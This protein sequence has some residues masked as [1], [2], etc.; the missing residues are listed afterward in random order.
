M[1]N[2]KV[3]LFCLIFFT[4]NN[5]FAQKDY[6][7]S[8]HKDLDDNPSRLF[9]NDVH[10]KAGLSCKDCHGG[11]ASKEDM[12]A[13]MNKSTGFRGVPKGDRISE[14]CANC[15][16]NK[17][18]IMKFSSA[19]STNQLEELKSSAHG[20]LS[21]NGKDRILQCTNCH[22]AHGIKKKNDP[23]SSVYPVNI[24][25]TCTK[26]HNNADY[27]KNYNSALPVDQLSKYRTSVHGV[28]NQKGNSKTAECAS[29]HGS[30][31]I[32]SSKDV[33]S[34]VY[35][36]NIPGTCSKCH[37]D[38]EYMKQ[39][40]IPTNQFA[41]YRNSVHGKAV[42]EKQE[43]SAPVCN[44]CHGN[45][46]ATPPGI[47]SISNVCGNCHVL[48]SQ[49]FSESPH[50]KAFDQMKYP[51]CETCH[52]NHEILIAKDKLLGVK[53]GAVC[54]QCHSETKNS[55]GYFVAKMMSNTIDSLIIYDSIAQKL[56]FQAEQKG[57]E[58]EDAKFMLR[59]VH[60]A[61]LQARTII[62]S[63]NE[64]KF[65][66]VTNK[67]MTSAK[68]VISDAKDAIHEYSYRRYGL[69]VATLTISLLILG[70]FIYIKRIEKK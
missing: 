43:L 28:L 19:I 48:N 36:L 24:P 41:K 61:R 53:E 34:T 52:G 26:C 54:L 6:C 33:R 32:L 60:Q 62:H 16:S 11:D 55:S 8:C 51:E 56:I 25:S 70:L 46:G 3:I 49:L 67:G 64:N 27:M 66:E 59:D 35:K 29:C 38:N 1:K 30:H 20:K 4:S 37:S 45:H 65:K 47:T 18:Y 42:F 22:N 50:K 63:F 9:M 57:M 58:I 68:Y 7:I 14:I 39:F 2:L 23:T 69:G 40:N 13:A 12:D 21:I 44:D 5:L 31:N 15:H 17:T 10:M